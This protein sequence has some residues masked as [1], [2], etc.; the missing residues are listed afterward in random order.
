[1][2]EKRER[3]KDRQK[4]N[5]LSTFFFFEMLGVRTL[6]RFNS[7]IAARVF[8]EL[9]LSADSP[10]LGVYDGQWSGSGELVTSLNPANNEVLGTVRL[11][12]VD[13]YRST[14]A[15]A[16]E[17]WPKWRALPAPQRGEIVRQ[18]GNKLREHKDALG[19]LISLEMGKIKAEGDGEVQE[20]IDICDYAAG[21]SRMINGLVMP[22]ERAN[23]TLLERWH[24]LGVVG[25]ISA[26]NFPVAVY[27]WNAAISMVTGNMTLWKGAPSTSLL[28]VACTKLVADVLE[29]NGVDGAV[30]ATVCGG[31]D[32]GQ[33]MAEDRD[34][35]LVSFTGSTEVGRR[36]GVAV[37]QRFGKSILELGGNNAVIVNGDAN[38]DLAVPGVLF[39]SVGTAGQRC[40]SCRRVLL[41]DDV[42]DEFVER[43]V[44]AYGQVKIGNPLD[45]G[46]LC[47]P[48]H[49][50]AALDTYDRVVDQVRAEGGTI[51]A[52]GSRVQLHNGNFVQP[53]I[54][55]GLTP[56]SPLLQHEAFVPIVHTLRFSDIDE[57]IAINNN[58]RQGLSS[59]LFTRDPNL[60]FKW[61]GEAGSD[62]GIAGVNLP[63]SGAEI[64]G[65]FGGE[66]ETGGGRE[67][68]SSS[69]QG[70]MRRQTITIN[71]GD[72]LPLAQGIKFD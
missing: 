62:C 60:I 6:F 46:V 14:V 64:G 30:C 48:L 71:H 29:S 40:T 49:N 54:T 4:N 38:L 41:H 57:A 13:E 37:Q 70:Y 27:G 25:V 8:S 58:V 50:K 2:F 20:W 31:A 32:V 24:P 44:A 23:H 9:N 56:D 39:A 45:E 19:S 65:A 67:S 33:A 51:L 69:W 52:G 3:K 42:H 47:G 18:I 15:K 55:G 68:G 21:L 17:A 34:V 1:L 7:T 26:F 12:T 61:I 35:P 22:S 72:D 59:A 53:T 11:G 5:F 10:N 43:L 28:S 16:K 63:T 36:V 66:K